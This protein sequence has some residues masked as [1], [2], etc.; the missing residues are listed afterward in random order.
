MSEFGPKYPGAGIRAG[1][2]GDNVFA[3]MASVKRALKNGGY[4]DSA[5]EEYEAEAMSGD[6][7]NAIKVTYAYVTIAYEV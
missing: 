6:Y 2:E 5:F 1:F 4:P 7:E 3:I